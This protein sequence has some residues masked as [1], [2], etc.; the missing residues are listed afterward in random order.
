LPGTFTKICKDQYGETTPHPCELDS[1]AHIIIPNKE[2]EEQDT[3]G[4]DGKSSGNRSFITFS[5]AMSF[6]NIT[7]NNQRILESKD[8]IC[9]VK[10]SGNYW[11]VF[12]GRRSEKK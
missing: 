8:F 11:V 6:A 10:K 3:R 1:I 12:F 2:S 7:A 5:E 9:S 4:A